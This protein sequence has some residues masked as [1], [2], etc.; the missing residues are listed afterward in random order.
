MSSRDW[1]GTAIKGR[2]MGTF[3]PKY[4][5]AGLI[6]LI[7]AAC[8]PSV[9]G[10]DV[11][12]T[13]KIAP[14][15]APKS[16]LGLP[17]LGAEPLVNSEH[18]GVY[19]CSDAYSTIANVAGGLAI[20]NC[21]KNEEFDVEDYGY[22]GEKPGY[23]YGGYFANVGACAW[24]K[25]SEALKE[26]SGNLGHCSGG[27]GY[28]Y[29][30]FYSQINSG[31]AE[32]GFYV[33]N[34]VACEEYANAY[35]WGADTAAGPIRNVPAYTESHETAGFPAL[36][37]RY[38]TNNGKYVMVRD[39]TVGGGAGNWV[40]VERSCLPATLPTADE[41]LSPKATVTTGTPTGVATPNATL[42]GYVNP[43]GVPT[44][45]FFEYGT[46]ES[47]GS[48]TT[49]ESA[50]EGTTVVQENA[51]ISGLAPGTTYYFR[52][53]ASS[54]TGEVF[55]GPV[56][57]TTQPVPS[58]TTTAASGVEEEQA[59]LNGEVNGNGL[60]TTYHFEYGE[61]TAYGS[62]TSAVGIGSG[63]SSPSVAVTG[64]KP[65]TTY[66]YRIVAESTAGR[67]EGADHTFTTPVS[68]TWATGEGGSL[69]QLFY[70]GP[71][72]TV[73]EAYETS[74][75]EWI[76]ESVS[77]GYGASSKVTW[78]PGQSAVQELFY[79]GSGGAVY[80][81]YMT[82][83]NEWITQVISSG[84]GATGQVTFGNNQVFYVGS[85]G[86]VYEIYSNQNKWINQAIS[87]GYG[88]TGQLTFA[89]NQVFYVGSGGT[90]YEI[91]SNEGKWIT[92][93]VGS[94]A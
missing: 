71:N 4:I 1:G 19:H 14:G 90:V 39:T 36:K 93:S 16:G 41:E 75:A 65:G 49:T 86:T 84:Y 72:G 69:Q 37:W 12:M 22:G 32:D 94:G 67:A 20:G 79:V 17:G 3:A 38:V 78:A 27:I 70:V 92:Q 35:P 40:F 53:V 52:I 76:T 10:A 33:T 63:A 47:Y 83:K 80:E 89:N 81:A 58:V 11:D 18:D 54:A 56:A 68:V 15:P 74:K 60:N 66:H 23:F 30:T 87:S 51:A 34:R 88:A 61:N 28:E 50:G 31:S 85:G 21:P 2:R 24:A 77:S 55:G 64:L 46:T 91:Y 59:T 62:S 42:V 48:Y 29:G 5:L 44:K 7:C 45:Y 57:F 25:I 8:I 73:Y 26:K 13:G 43:N 9:A 6:V 82:S